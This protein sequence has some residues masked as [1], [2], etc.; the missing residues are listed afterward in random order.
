MRG[1]TLIELTVVCLLFTGLTAVLTLAWTRGARTITYSDKLTARL[2]QLSLVR[3]RIER[4]LSETHTLSLQV[5]PSA[6][7]FALPQDDYFRHLDQAPVLAL[8]YLSENKLF[9]RQ[10]AAPMDWTAQGGKEVV[11]GVTAFE[12]SQVENL[13]RIRIESGRLRLDSS[14]RVRN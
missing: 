11:G 4:E 9:R 6:L 2:N 14:T 8:Y 13:V 5:R 3:H 12:V 1:Y 10:L 7:A